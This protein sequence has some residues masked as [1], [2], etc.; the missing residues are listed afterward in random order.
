MTDGRMQF[1][2]TFGKPAGAHRVEDDDPFRIL[3][4]ADLGGSALPFELRKPLRVDIDNVDAI[5]ARI[6]PRLQLNLDGAQVEIGFSALDDFHPDR[7]FA[8][9]APFVAL[10]QLRSELAD[11]AQFRRAA[12]A[13]GAPT[14]PAAAPHATEVD[15]GDIERLL[16][17]KPSAPASPV[18]PAAA[19][20]DVASWI[21]GIVAPHVVPDIAGEQAQLIAAVDA[22][23]AEQMRRMLHHPAFQA[24]EANWRGLDRLVRE[25]ELDEALQLFLL[26]AP[27]AALAQ[28]VA[29]HAAD[30]T[31]SALH[32]HL[33]GPLTQP[34]DGKPWS[35]LVSDLAIGADLDDLRLVAALGAMA[36]RAG[37][38]LLA[39]AEPSLIGCADVMQLA[40][41]KQWQVPDADAAAFWAA[42]RQSPVAP[43]VGLALPRVLARMPYGRDTDPVSAFAFEELAVREHEAYLWS[44]AAFA[45]ALLAGQAFMEGGWNMELAA[46]LD[47][48]DLP[49]HVFVEDGEK[50]QQPCAEVSISESA[51]EA[52][53]EQGTMAL[54]SYRNRNAV[55]LLRWQS[56]AEPLQQLRGAWVSA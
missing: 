42:L 26:D 43:W 50:H 27:R 48:G 23:I 45:L 36:G 10:R 51:G 13:L 14:A 28:D 25:L 20:V 15:A 53:L 29:H 49:S 30:L 3:V 31:Q 21:R 41:P 55:R 19:A 46:G 17:R 7:L 47:I 22:A 12:A 16:G 11:P 35:L 5:F 54:L 1:G 56:I 6:A 8:R 39:G 34:P 52:I 32:H 44:G 4:L 18:A 24:L 9:L 33:C 38:P 40:Q 2:F 37:A